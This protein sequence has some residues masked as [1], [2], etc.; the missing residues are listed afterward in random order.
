[1]TPAF[2][3]RR[4]ADEFDR[5]VDSSSTGGDAASKAPADLRELAALA[6]SLTRLEAPAPRAAFSADLRERLMSAAATELTP[7]ADSE[8]RDK[9]TVRGLAGPAAA[10]RRQRRLTVAVATL[11]VIGGTAGTALAS[12]NALPG[13]TLYP[14]KRAIENIHTGLSEGDQSKGRTLMADA[15]TRLGEAD[16]LA[17]RRQAD[18]AEEIASTLTAFSQQAQRASTLLMQDYQAHHDT[19]SITAL[20][21]FAKQGITQLSQLSADLPPT[22]QPALTQA[23]Q[24][25]LAIDQ[26]AQQLC[27]SCGA[28]S[29]T[30]LPSSLLTA[31]G[32]TL[33]QLG[34]ALTGGK[35]ASTRDSAD[36]SN[37][38]GIKLPQLNAG[39]LPPATVPRL[40]PGS[41]TPAGG[42][43]LPSAT[44]SSTAK[45]HR[46]TTSGAQSSPSQSPSSSPTSLGETVNKVT[47]GVGDLVGGVVKGLLGG[48]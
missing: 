47:S 1:M 6:S 25:L 16:T 14:V 12:Q 15:N 4:R 5:L 31:T 10:Q 43:G 26:A 38:T 30:Q 36:G 37:Q 42:A 21:Q 27:P 41:S 19:T 22:A 18:N 3:A 45:K 32:Q 17:A 9:L 24:T 29:I 40:A 11:A 44:T 8:V 46:S 48:G 28:A 7:A 39:S 35:A 13:D 20:H 33:H 2:P 23:T 34:G